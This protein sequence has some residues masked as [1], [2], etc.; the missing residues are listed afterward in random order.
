MDA[1]TENKMRCV[2]DGRC[3]CV[4]TC[5]GQ[6]LPTFTH[7]L[8]YTHNLTQS[9]VPLLQGVRTGVSGL[10]DS[11]WTVLQGECWQDG[12][13]G[14]APWPLGT[15]F[16]GRRCRERGR[17]AVQGGS[18]DG[19]ARTVRRENGVRSRTDRVLSEA[20]CVAA[21]ARRCGGGRRAAGSNLHEMSGTC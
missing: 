3:A 2:S 17:S 16:G 20:L 14:R 11:V 4:G 8:L 9:A 10:R 13:A 21:H 12:A 19:A 7:L 6:S 15:A 18:E 5:V 1:A